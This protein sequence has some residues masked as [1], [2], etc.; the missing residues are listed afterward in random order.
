M[1]ESCVTTVDMVGFLKILT[2]LLIFCDQ[3]YSKC[4]LV[5]F[6][7]QSFCKAVRTIMKL[8]GFEISESLIHLL[9]IA[10]KNMKF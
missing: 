7:L 9:F 8:V 4:F 2:W 1:G 10:V 6:C 5:N 3:H